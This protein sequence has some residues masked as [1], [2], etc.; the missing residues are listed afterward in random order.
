[1]ENENE[2]LIE[3]DE[4][5]SKGNKI[6]IIGISV[7]MGLLLVVWVLYTFC[8]YHVSVVGASMNPTLKDG[9]VL[10]VNTL[11]TAKKGDIILIEGE[12]ENKLLIKRYIAGGGDTVTIK[13]G[14]V[15]VNGE[16]QIES[17][18]D[19]QGETFYPNVS[20]R[21]NVEECTW[22]LKENE[23][24]YLGD[25]RKNSNDSRYSEYGSCTED[26]IIGVV[27]NFAVKIKGVS[28]SINSV[29]VWIKNLFG[30]KG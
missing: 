6:F 11:K 25:N 12:A 1:M 8:F 10:L 21:T 18:F 27:G 24:F 5:Q 2:V 23:V 13:D 22:E 4:N 26:Q 9:D 20:D 15:F 16:K 29:S 17:Y 30:I 3:Q 7:L 28:K 19:V 14:Y